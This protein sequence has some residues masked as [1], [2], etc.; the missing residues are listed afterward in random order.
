M[1]ASGNSNWF[2]EIPKPHGETKVLSNSTK[3]L[4]HNS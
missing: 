2:L 4:I 1:R 3:L